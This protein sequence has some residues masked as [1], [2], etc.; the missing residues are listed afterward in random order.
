MSQKLVINLIQ[1]L[2]TPHNNTLIEQFV[3]REDVT[4]K[5]WYA[6]SND[7]SRYQWSKDITNQYLPAYIYGS[8]INF[9]F[10]RYCLTRREERFVIVGWMNTNTRLLHLLFFLLRR[11]YNHW[12]DLPNPRQENRTLIRKF[13][14]W[15]SY[16]LL[17]YSNCQVFGV[18]RTTMNCFRAWGY[19]ERKIVNLPIFIGVNEDLVV[20]RKRR[21]EI[22]ERF[23]VPS[24]GFLLSAGSRLV[25]EKGYDLLIHAISLLPAELRLKIKVVLV[26][27]GEELLNLAEQIERLGLQKVVHL[28]KWMDIEDFKALISNSDIFIHPARFDS[29]GGTTLGMAL[30]VAVIGSSGAGAAVD[31]MEH[32]I[33]GLLYEP[34]DVQAL[35]GY[36]EQLLDDPVRRQR[37]ATAGRKT[38]LEWPPSRG[39][40][41]LLKHSI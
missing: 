37:L 15:A 34:T 11:P 27:S 35:A 26:G 8:R 38:A 16:K 39:V 4:L 5:V 30:G 7:K 32:G 21:G 24:H 3:G 19:P 17:L 31:R 6:E 40:D 22:L 36:I 33:N 13:L 28:E 1:D 25:R 12:T 23:K 41:I 29:Y 2:A 14:R 18:G 9:A 20:Y 10:L